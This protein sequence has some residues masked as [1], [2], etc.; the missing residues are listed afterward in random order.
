M[1]CLSMLVAGLLAA[2]AAPATP[3]PAAPAAPKEITVTSKSPQAVEAFKKGRDLYENGHFNE[4]PAEFKKALELD[5]DFALAHALNGMVLTGAEGLKEIERGAAKLAGLPEAEA[6]LVQV[7]LATKQG[8]SAK[9][10]AM[11]RKLTASVSSDW[12]AHYVLAETAF[13]AGRWDDVI[14]ASRKATELNPKAGPALLDLGIA[15]MFTRQLEQAVETFKKYI[16][17]APGEGSGHDALGEALM[18]SGKLEEAEASIKKATELLPKPYNSWAGLSQIRALRGDWKGA[19]EAIAK[20]KETAIL[21][22]D[23]T[24]LMDRLANTLNAEGKTAEALKALAQ[25]EKE[26]KDLGSVYG[27]VNAILDRAWIHLDAGKNKEALAAVNEALARIGKDPFSPWGVLNVQ[28][29]GFAYRAALEARMGKKDDAQKTLALVDEV[30]KKAPDNVWYRSAFHW[31]SGQ[32]ALASGDAKAA[33]AEFAQCVEDDFYCRYNQMQALT[34]AGDK[35]GAD[36]V[37]EKLLK[38]P[39]RGFSYL[40]VRAKLGGIPKAPPAAKEAPKKK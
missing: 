7:Y 19:Y 11:A 21:P 28:S 30:A 26:S 17:L 8:D 6:L 18:M 3:P 36:A 13:T 33:A 16:E 27:G 32:I 22:D 29:T 40:Y 31:A 5:P 4:S 9:A 39:V 38:V 24:D 25:M 23:K 20:A 1:N 37:K 10:L 34:K 15:Y 14:A 35:A 2:A 12:R